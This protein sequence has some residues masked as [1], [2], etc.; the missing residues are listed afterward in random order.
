M[1]MLLPLVMEASWRQ[2]LPIWQY[3][4]SNQRHASAFF[5]ILENAYWMSCSVA[6]IAKM[7]ERQGFKAQLLQ[8]LADV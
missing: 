4:L 7:N 2:P 8:I 1:P 6:I 5:Y 3:G